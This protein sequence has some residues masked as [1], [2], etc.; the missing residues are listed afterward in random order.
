MACKAS[1]T[2]DYKDQANV[3]GTGKCE[4]TCDAAG[5][6]KGQ[7]FLTLPAGSAGPMNVDIVKTGNTAL[8]T[9]TDN[10]VSCVAVFQCACGDKVDSQMSEALGLK[11]SRPLIADILTLG[12]LVL[13]DIVKK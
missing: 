2:W 12:V 6:C 8:F 9:A 7:W 13:K 3:Q 10:P 4:G 11:Y 1:V 5:G